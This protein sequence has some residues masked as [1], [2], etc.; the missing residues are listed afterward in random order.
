MSLCQAGEEKKTLSFCYL[1]PFASRAML[2]V[3][4]IRVRYHYFIVP[5][6]ICLTNMCTFYLKENIILPGA[7]V[8]LTEHSCKCIQKSTTFHATQNA[9][10]DV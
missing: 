6:N 8:I 4:W 5:L 9:R 7:W 1:V 2:R 10:R 3:W